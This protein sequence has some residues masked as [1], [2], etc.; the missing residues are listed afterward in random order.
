MIPR[1]LKTVKPLSFELCDVSPK[2]YA[3]SIG[4]LAC[5]VGKFLYEYFNGSYSFYCDVPTSVKV[6]ASI[7]VLALL[8]RKAIECT[9]GAEMIDISIKTEHGYVLI[10]INT[11]S[12]EM[13]EETVG[14]L[15]ELSLNSGATLSVSGNQLV[16]KTKILKTATIIIHI[17][18]LKTPL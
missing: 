15:S 2:T 9:L 3:Y 17:F 18:L 16:Y 8:L 6:Y 14:K 10:T 7:D 12:A 11:G 13:N 4:E 5:D 1:K